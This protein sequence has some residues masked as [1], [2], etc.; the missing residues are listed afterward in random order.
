MIQTQLGRGPRGGGRPGGRPG[1]G[2]RRGGG[3]RGRRRFGG[4][5]PYYTESSWPIYIGPTVD[6]EVVPICPDSFPP[7]KTS[8]GILTCPL[9]PRTLTGAGSEGFLLGETANPIINI[10]TI[11][12]KIQAVKPVTVAQAK[13]LAGMGMGAIQSAIRYAPGGSV[14]VTP[15]QDAARKKVQGHIQWHLDNLKNFPDPKA[16]YPSSDD[17]KMYVISA[18][19]EYNAATQNRVQERDIVYKS[20][21][22]MLDGMQKSVMGT[23]TKNWPWVVAAGVATTVGIIL[24]RGKK[25]SRRYRKAA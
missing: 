21:S 18:Y 4:G 15:A 12:R 3:F 6:S 13:D 23:L 14:A 10:E 20:F 24:M 22:D 8:E 16:A 7:I 5:G 1:G 9:K 2:F 11:V 19:V 17:L 25:R